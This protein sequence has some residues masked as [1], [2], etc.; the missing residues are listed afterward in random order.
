MSEESGEKSHEPTQKRLDDLR[1]EGRVARSQDLLAAAAQGGFLLAIAGPGLW[2][3]DRAGQVRVETAPLPQAK[4][5]W[6]I[7]LA[8]GRSILLTTT[9]GTLFSSS[10]FLSTKRVCG[11]QPSNASTS[12]STPSTICSMRSTSPPKS[13][14][15]G[16]SIMFIL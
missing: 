5:D 3:L 10:A 2:S 9:T 11:I 15:P 4:R 1:R 16:V 13:A 8:P 12:S 6:R 7:G 14:W